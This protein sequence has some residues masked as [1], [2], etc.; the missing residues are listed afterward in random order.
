MISQLA[1]I[2]GLASVTLSLL[3]AAWQTRQLT[4]QTRISNMTGSAS[5]YIGSAQLV[6]SAHAPLLQDPSLRAYFYDDKECGAD[7]SNRLR[8]LT[9]AELMADA[10]EYGLMM[11]SHLPVD[12][13]WREYPKNLLAS[14]PILRQVVLDS[15]RLWPRMASQVSPLP[16]PSSDMAEVRRGT[17]LTP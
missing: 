2:V 17:E 12:Q 4:R 14:S 9:I 13:Q 7:D 11:A 16:V 8:L 5:A 1:T 15:P 3:I 10:C 6:A